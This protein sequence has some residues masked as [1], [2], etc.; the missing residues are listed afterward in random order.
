MHNHM[1]QPIGLPV[2]SWSPPPQ[3]SHEVLAGKY[4]RLEP[5]NADC[6]AE[7]LYNANV[8]DK[9]GR[10]WTYLPY[11]PFHS[12][13]DYKAWVESNCKSRDP[14]FYAILP[15]SSGKP[16]GIASY[17]R[18]APSSGS[19]EVG[20]VHFSNLLMRSIVAT[21]SMILMMKHAFELG[22]R[23]YEW[24][25]DALNV[26]SRIAGQRLGLSIEGIFRQATV[27]KGRNRDTAWYAATDG[28][29]PELCKRYEQ[30]LDPANFDSEGRQL[31]RLSDLTRPLLFRAD[32]ELR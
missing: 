14:L 5:L 22:Y 18:I 9:E 23:R 32:P 31:V 10:N 28:D 6:H 15:H 7:D 13:T 3:P 24:K 26:G 11:G 4:C 30:W 29:W 17:L 27:Y 21:E 20:H 8:L 1:N 19:I 2:P 16:A 12:L 25:C